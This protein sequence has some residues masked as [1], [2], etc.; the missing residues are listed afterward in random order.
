MVTVTRSSLVEKIYTHVG[1]S[2]HDSSQI[3][4]SVLDLIGSRLETGE[5]VKLSG[6]GTFSV[7]RKGERVG[8]NPKTGVEVPILPRAV[9]TFRPSQLL[10]GRL[11]DKTTTATTPGVQGND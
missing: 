1:L 8:R 11:N 5:T 6:F 10:C 2:R 9:L 4:E 3:L 7:R